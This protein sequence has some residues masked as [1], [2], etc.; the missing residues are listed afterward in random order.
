MEVEGGSKM[1]PQ[2]TELDQQAVSVSI[3]GGQITAKLL[4][5]VMKQLIKR[6]ETAA[7]RNGQMDIKKL[8]RQGKQLECVEL[9]CGELRDIKKQLNQYGVDFAVLRDGKEKV[10]LYFKAQDVDRVYKGMQKCLNQR[11]QPKK[12][13]IRMLLAKAIEKSKAMTRP[14]G[15]KK[16]KEVER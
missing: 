1:M 3:E 16:S 8:D 12:K 2:G 14:T 10:S 11:Q 7:D 9:P 6:R 4:Y 5:Q 15:P 13:P